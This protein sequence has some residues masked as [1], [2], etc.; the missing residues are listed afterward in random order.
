M[1]PAISAHHTAC[2]SFADIHPD[3]SHRANLH[4]SFGAFVGSHAADDD[5]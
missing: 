4:R 3:A 5:L 2:E 1:F